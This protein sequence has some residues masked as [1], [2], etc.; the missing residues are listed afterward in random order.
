MMPIRLHKTTQAEFSM[1]RSLLNPRHPV[2]ALTICVAGICSL[3]SVDLQAN[4]VQV[5]RYS[6]LTAVPTEAQRELLATTVVVRLPERIQT[7]GEAVRYLLHRSGYRLAAPES[8][9]PDTLVLYSL[10]LPAVHRTLGPMTL[11]DAL[12]TL[13]GPVFNLVEDPVHRLITFERCAADQVATRDG[14]TAT[15]MEVVQDDN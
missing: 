4:D 13:A 10:P 15:E 6:V 7:V 14:G 8:I 5:G 2:A 1:K 11:E 3:T 12:E 9:G